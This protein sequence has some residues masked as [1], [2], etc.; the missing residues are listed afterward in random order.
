MNTKLS[1]RIRPN[2][3]AAPWVIEDIK[4]MEEEIRF[5]KDVVLAGIQ[6]DLRIARQE[7]DELKECLRWYVE[8]DDTNEGGKWEESNAHWLEGKRRAMRALGMEEE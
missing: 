2:S 8:N 5:L 3:E 1:D 7:R 6:E 4:R